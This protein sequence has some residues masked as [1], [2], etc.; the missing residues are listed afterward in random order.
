[1]AWN[2]PRNW[3]EVREAKETWRTNRKS[4]M[5]PLEALRLGDELRAHVISLRA[6]WPSP[7]ER[8]ADIDMHA[9]VA[10]MLRRR[11]RFEEIVSAGSHAACPVCGSDEVAKL[12]SPF[13]VGRGGSSP[14]RT[15]PSFPAGGG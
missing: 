7:A 12:W 6:D 1:M 10:E 2:S 8:D 13:A 9:R 5:T 11:E 15:A 4:Q 3:A 14:S